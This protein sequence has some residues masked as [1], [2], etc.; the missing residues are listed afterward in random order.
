MSV[1][2]FIDPWGDIEYY[3]VLLERADDQTILDGV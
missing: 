3:K 1:D 2:P